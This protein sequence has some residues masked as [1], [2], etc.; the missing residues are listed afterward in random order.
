MPRPSV[1]AYKQAV[2]IRIVAR[3][4]DSEKKKKKKAYPMRP[5]IASNPKVRA[6]IVDL[7]SAF[8]GL[9]FGLFGRHCDGLFSQGGY[10]CMYACL[11]DAL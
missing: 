2:L 9:G 8:G 11:T 1:G 5:D 7:C 3:W 6:K 4:E 10:K